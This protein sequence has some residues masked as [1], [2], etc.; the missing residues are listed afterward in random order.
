MATNKIFSKKNTYPILILLGKRKK[1]QRKNKFIHL[2]KQ[3]VILSYQ[4]KYNYSTFIETGTYE[5]DMIDAL[6]NN[7][8]SLFSIEL[9]EKL[10]EKAVN[11]FKNN[12]NIKILQGDS[13]EVLK[14]I[15]PTIKTPTIFWLDAHYSQGETAKGSIDTPIEQEL[16]TILS[17]SIKNNVILIDDARLFNGEND[18]PEINSLKNNILNTYPSITF[19]VTDD[20]IRIF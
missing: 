15:L 16:N 14:Q 4:K 5:G 1:I 6:K 18:Y 13:A 11:R 9:G 3:R 2:E 19:E 12:S 7:F 17:H 20:I 8:K 10:Y